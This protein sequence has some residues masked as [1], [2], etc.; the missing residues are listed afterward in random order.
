MQG[1]SYESLKLTDRKLWR[2]VVRAR[3]LTVERYFR[4][5]DAEHLDSLPPDIVRAVAQLPVPNLTLRQT[6]GRG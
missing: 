1:P 3:L 4:Y 2:S 5:S 6:P